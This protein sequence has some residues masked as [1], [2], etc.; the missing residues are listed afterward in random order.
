MFSDLLGLLE[1]ESEVVSP[2]L[3]LETEPVKVVRVEDVDQGTEGQAVIPVGG[4][5]G[6]RNLKIFRKKIFSRKYFSHRIVSDPVLDPHQDHLL[7][8]GPGPGGHGALGGPGLV[9]L[10]VHHVEGHG[11]PGRAG[12][13]AGVP[14]Q[15]GGPGGAGLTS[16]TEI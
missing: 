11:G 7:G 8:P 14:V 1:G 16:H 13:H 5:V 2:V 3:R 4:E 9:V 12:R 6:H 10:L 15:V